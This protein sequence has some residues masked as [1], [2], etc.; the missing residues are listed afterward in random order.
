MF[1]HDHR[2]FHAAVDETAKKFQAELHA[3]ISASQGTAIN[4]IERIQR[5]VPDDRIAS[6]RALRFEPARDDLI[7]S[8]RAGAFNQPLHRHA[9]SQVA[10]RAGIRIPPP[11]IWSGSRMLARAVACSTVTQIA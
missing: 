8:G 6:T 10:E 7:V 4:L 11:A 1:H 3:K 5:E 9:R 2:E